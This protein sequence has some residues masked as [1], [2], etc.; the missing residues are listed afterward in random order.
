MPRAAR[1]HKR[2]D[3]KQE[4]LKDIKEAIQGYFEAFPEEA[5][6]LKLKKEVVEV[7]L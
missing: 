3:T 2:T 6:R 7:N 1:R 4:A 5:E